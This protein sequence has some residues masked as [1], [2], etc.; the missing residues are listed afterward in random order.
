MKEKII[1]LLQSNEKFGII[2]GRIFIVN[3]DKNE[4]YDFDFEREELIKFTSN[5]NG[6]EFEYQITDKEALDMSLDEYLTSLYNQA[7]REAERTPQGMDEFEECY[8]LYQK[9]KNGLIS[10]IDY[11][12]QGGIC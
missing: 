11:I 8:S 10:A 6:K 9:Y 1:E 4:I 7:E 2:D 3:E 5:W 12:K